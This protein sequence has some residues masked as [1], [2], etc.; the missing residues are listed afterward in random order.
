M[1][2]KTR[3]ILAVE[4]AAAWVEVERDQVRKQKG[5]GPSAI[6]EQEKEKVQAEHKAPAAPPA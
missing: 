2:H 5:L 4:Q 1:T 3:P 6:V